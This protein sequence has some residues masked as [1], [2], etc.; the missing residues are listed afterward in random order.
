MA[1][2]SKKT[3]ELMKLVDTFDRVVSLLASYQHPMLLTLKETWD[4]GCNKYCQVLTEG[5]S[6][7]LAEGVRQGLR[8]INDFADYIPTANRKDFIKNTAKLS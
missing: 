4:T 5:V 6:A 3:V 7:A 1:K 2:N 8:G